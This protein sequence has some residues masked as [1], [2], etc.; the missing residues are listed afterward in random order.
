[1]LRRWSKQVHVQ[2]ARYL[3][4]LSSHSGALWVVESFLYFL[5][6]LFFD[7]FDRPCFNAISCVVC[8]RCQLGAGRK[9]VL[10]KCTDPWQTFSCIGKYLESGGKK[11]KKLDICSE[12]IL[13]P[14]FRNH[15]FD[16][17]WQCLHASDV[18]RCQVFNAYGRG[19][20]LGQ[21]SVPLHT[22]PFINWQEKN[23]QREGVEGVQN[24]QP[25]NAHNV[26]DS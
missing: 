15:G 7:W 21:V 3:C 22:L 12:N 6:F 10:E 20:L 16:N 19:S 1:M 17:L 11:H 26:I 9:S 25:T 23:E 24:T 8:P 2:I 18:I 4:W 14:A 5:Y 13:A